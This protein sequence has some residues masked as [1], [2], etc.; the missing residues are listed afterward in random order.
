[1]SEP[2]PTLKPEHFDALYSADPD[3]WDFAAS[4]YERDKYAL[5]VN[6]MPKLRYRSALEVGCSSAFLH[7]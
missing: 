4:P 2:I 6:A 5:T 1:M 7:A 3:P